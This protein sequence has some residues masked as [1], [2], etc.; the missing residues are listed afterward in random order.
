M[1]EPAPQ[2]TEQVEVPGTYAPGRAGVYQRVVKRCIDFVLSLV[3]MVA[4]GIVCLF[5]APAIKREDGGPVFYNATR[6]G[7]HGTTFKMYKFR[8]M[9][10]G[11]P[12]VM[13]EEGSAWVGDDDPRVT[14]TGAWLRRT[15]LDEFPQV[16]NILKGDM[17]F[18]G[19][20]PDVP[21]EVALYEPDEWRRLDVLP[22]IGGYAQVNGRNAISIKERHA[23]DNEYVNRVSFPLDV[24]I[25]VKSITTALGGKGINEG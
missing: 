21:E 12:R 17:S 20:R 13:D 24:S 11:A 15:S 14:R 7:L 3:G 5:V 1:T 22:G 18:I 9:R 2:D 16:I 4:L 6:V 25:F 8:S 23:L 10:V 19:P